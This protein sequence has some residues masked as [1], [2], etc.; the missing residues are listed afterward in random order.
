MVVNVM[1]AGIRG[2]ESRPVQ[3][4]V[5]VSSGLPCMEMVGSAGHEVKEAKE[6]VRVA[7]KN[8]NISI[9]PLRITINLSPADMPKEGTGYDLPIAAALLVSLGKISAK[10]ENTQIIAVVTITD[11]GPNLL[12]ISQQNPLKRDK[13]GKNNSGKVGPTVPSGLSFIT[14][15]TIL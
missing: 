13:N 14:P 7:L 9:P 8:M 15:F 12:K 2:I 10:A 3:V 6:R 4:E 1:T 5:D 11:A